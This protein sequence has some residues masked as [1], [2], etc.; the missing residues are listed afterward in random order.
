MDRRST[1]KVSK[2][3]KALFDMVHK[4]LKMKNHSL[5]L[6]LMLIYIDYKISKLK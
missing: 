2:E 3:T 5:T 4:K 1:I 6:D